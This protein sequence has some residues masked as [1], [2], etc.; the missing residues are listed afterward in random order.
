MP[1]EARSASPGPKE[2]KPASIYKDHNFPKF[3]NQARKYTTRP[4]EP[5]QP[6]TPTILPS[7]SLLENLKQ[8]RA[9]A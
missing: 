4:L 7:H 8:R 2:E 6:E 5:L 9:E 3:I 1:A